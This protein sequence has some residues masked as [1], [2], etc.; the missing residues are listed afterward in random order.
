MERSAAVC[1]PSKTKDEHSDH[2]R[3]L[4]ASVSAAA[5]AYVKTQIKRLC[6]RD[7]V[8]LCLHF[9][10]LLHKLSHLLVIFSDITTW[11]PKCWDN[12]SAAR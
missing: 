7:R 9:N 1:I 10:F 11:F 3:S 5:M 8:F 12:S 6:G 2:S 4:D